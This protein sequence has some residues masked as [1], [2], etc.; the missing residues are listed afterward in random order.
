MATKPSEKS[1]AATEWKKR[2]PGNS[3]RRR[4]C[5]TTSPVAC[6]REISSIASTACGIVSTARTS[7][8]LMCNV[9][10]SLS[11]LVLGGR[12][13]WLRWAV[14]Y[15]RFARLADSANHGLDQPVDALVFVIFHQM[16]PKLWSVFGSFA[17]ANR[18]LAAQIIFN[19]S[20]FVPAPLAIPGINAQCR[21][22]ARLAFRAARRGQKILWLLARRVAYAVQFEPRQRTDICGRRSFAHRF[23]QIHLHES[24]RHPASDGN[25]LVAGLGR[26]RIFRGARGGFPRR[27]RCHASDQK[28]IFLFRF[29]GLIRVVFLI[30]DLHPIS[31]RATHDFEGNVSPELIQAVGRPP[32][33]VRANGGDFGT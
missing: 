12:L 32:P 8:S 13:C 7:A 16:E 19:E 30:R 6:L 31:Y 10:V 18:Q 21:K 27:P 3:N 23:R 29:F 1:A 25:S 15:G 33:L 4:G 24:R 14:F 28:P 22:V 17:S 26:V 2:P 20:S 5:T 11:A 9:I